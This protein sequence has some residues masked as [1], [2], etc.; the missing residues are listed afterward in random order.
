VSLPWALRALASRNFRLFFSGQIVS[1]VGSWITTATNAWLVFHL[2]KRTDL[3]GLSA[4]LSQIPAFVL[5]P[6]AGVW[7]DRWDLRRVLVLTQS[8]S[9]LESIALA[10]LCWHGHLPVPVMVGTIL[11]LQAFQGVINSVDLPAR[12]SF[13]VQ[14]VDDRA[15]L[16][17]AIA[18]NSTMVNVS[19]AIGPA[20]AGAL[21][22]LAGPGND[23]RG[24]AWCYSLDVVSYIGVIYALA[25]MKPNPVERARHLHGARAAFTE[26]LLYVRNF[27]ALRN[28]LLLLCATSFFGVSI[29]TQLAAIAPGLLHVRADGYGLLVGGIGGGATVSALYLATRRTTHGLPTLLSYAS[30]MFGTAL[31]GLSF[32]HRYGVALLL[33]PVIGAAMI[34]QSAGTNTLCQTLSEDTKRGRV[35]AFFTMS[36]MGMVPLGAVALGA[37]SQHLGMRPTL[38]AY[39]A[40]V[41]VASL[42]FGPTLRRISR[43]MKDAATPAVLAAAGD[44]PEAEAQ[45]TTVSK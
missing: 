44:E 4:F 13:G 22:A 30:L 25:I 37:L 18:L 29:N 35:M 5:A 23:V 40:A 19:R 9:L 12:Q 31:L 17:N 3:L 20:I 27:P 7:I 28:A 14:M 36:F 16:T 26:G 24:A 6:I 33:A 15:H 32:V 38:F 42:T 8:L 2:T 21:I 45:A 43:E 39:A 41:I 11:G 1:L 34:L 10:A